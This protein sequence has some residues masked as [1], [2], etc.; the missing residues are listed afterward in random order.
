ML[1]QLIIILLL[2]ISFF[3]CQKPE[4]PIFKRIDDKKIDAITTD[5]VTISGKAVYYN[6]NKMGL[7]VVKSDINVYLRDNYIGK[8]L[9]NNL[10]E[11][12]PKMEFSIPF[13]VKLSL[14]DLA[15]KG[16]I[17]DLFMMMNKAEIPI[18][19][20]GTTT[21]KVLGISLNVPID[22]SDKLVF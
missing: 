13:K 10:V 3:A 21:V 18:R 17:S 12:K 9:Q 19:Y 11:V 6:Q 5:S 4:S 16:V 2:S 1:K 20:K 15:K 8:V 22:Y 14:S 7:K